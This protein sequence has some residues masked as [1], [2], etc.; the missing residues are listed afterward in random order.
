[1][2]DQGFTRAKSDSCL[3]VNATSSEDRIMLA[4]YVD[5][6]LILSKNALVIETFKQ[7]IQQRFKMVD[8]GPAT[9]FIGFEIAQSQGVVS[10]SQAKYIKDLLVKAKMLGANP[11]S[12]PLPPGLQLQKAAVG[13]VILEDPQPYRSIVGALLYAS[14][15]T[16]VDIAT[17]VAQLCKYMQEPRKSHY[18]ALQHILRYLCGTINLGIKYE[19]SPVSCEGYADASFAQDVDSRKSVTCFVFT[20]ACGAISWCSRQQTIVATSTMESELIAASAAADEAVFIRQLL[21]DL[22]YEQADA[23][24]IYCDNQPMLHMVTNST[25]TQ[26]NK[27]IDVKFRS[28][29]ERVDKR[30]VSLVYKASDHLPADLLTKNLPAP[31]FARHRASLMNLAA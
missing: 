12:T 1:L 24:V 16:R 26:R 13:D 30:Q 27:H 15:S 7:N 22:N 31:A 23:T 3:F 10:V 11:V 5:D 14:T 28:V 29:E 18:T 20:I 19:R 8:G 9:Y 21:A 6:I 4:I 25:T 2:L 17:A